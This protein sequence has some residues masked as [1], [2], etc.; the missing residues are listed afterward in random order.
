M[1][2]DS[3]TRMKSRLTFLELLAQL[4]VGGLSVARRRIYYSMSGMKS[5]LDKVCVE[6]G[7]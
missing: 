6:I 1:T 7:L 5:Y 3:D 4:G 2:V